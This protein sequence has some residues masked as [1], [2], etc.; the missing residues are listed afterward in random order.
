MMIGI[1]FFS[2]NAYLELGRALEIILEENNSSVSHNEKQRTV[3]DS[4]F[5]VCSFAYLC[6]L[7]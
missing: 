5:E 6:G 7:L 4:H 3:S 1:R 2:L